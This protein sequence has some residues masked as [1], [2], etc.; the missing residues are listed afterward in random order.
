MVPEFRF[1]DD[2]VSREEADGKDFR[3]GLLISGKFASKHEVLSDL[4][5]F[6]SIP[7][8]GEKSRLDLEL[9]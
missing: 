9:L 6:L 4:R 7:S 1:S 3:A 2:F 5:I 8:S